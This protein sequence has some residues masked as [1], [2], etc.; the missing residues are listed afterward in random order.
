MILSWWLAFDLSCFLG[1]FSVVGARVC[2]G[3]CGANVFGV[4][5]GV[6]KEG[7]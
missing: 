1:L 2:G 6:V 5:T 7:I 4:G 3:A